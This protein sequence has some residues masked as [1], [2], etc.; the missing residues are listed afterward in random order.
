MMRW[1]YI[2]EH[3]QKHMYISLLQQNM[4]CLLSGLYLYQQWFLFRSAAS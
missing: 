4:H 1:E 2:S 3:K